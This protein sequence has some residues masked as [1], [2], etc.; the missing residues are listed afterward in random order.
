[1]LEDRG[2]IPSRVFVDGMPAI[3][4]KGKKGNE[5][6]DAVFHALYQKKCRYMHMQWKREQTVLTSSAVR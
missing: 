3:R 5:G 1:M 6:S 2:R 4:E